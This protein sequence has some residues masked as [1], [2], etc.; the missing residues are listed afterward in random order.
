[1]KEDD[2][3]V[4]IHKYC[5]LS[6]MELLGVRDTSEFRAC[7]S[8][9]EHYEGHQFPWD[10]TW[11]EKSRIQ[12]LHEGG[13]GSLES[14]ER[15]RAIRQAERE[16]EEAVNQLERETRAAQKARDNLNRA[17]DALAAR[18]AQARPKFGLE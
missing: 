18:I 3:L 11:V 10:T 16:Y 17:V 2:F 6:I 12:S 14:K 9:Y 8:A 13:V 5:G 15:Q 7:K 1:M 4:G